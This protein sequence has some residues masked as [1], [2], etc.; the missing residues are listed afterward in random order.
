M[1]EPT[2][3][4]RQT[5][6]RDAILGAMRDSPGPLTVREIHERGAALVPGLGIATVYHTLK[7]LQEA[8]QI[9]TVVLPSGESRY[10]A[11][12]LGHHHH[13]HCRVCGWNPICGG[14]FLP[15]ARY[16]HREVPHDARRPRCP[17]APARTRV[18]PHGGEPRRAR[19]LPA[20]RTPPSSA[21]RPRRRAPSRGGRD[22]PRAVH[23]RW[24]PG[25]ARFPPSP[26]RGLRAR[27]G[28]A[29]GSYR[30]PGG[31]PPAPP[32]R[33]PLR[34]PWSAPPGLIRPAARPGRALLRIDYWQ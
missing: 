29:R 11:A 30:L 3:G 16:L 32:A 23:G 28:T 31:R 10:E 8:R 17:H 7:L 6:Q 1:S 33:R 22:E 14:S 27:G 24:C 12:E 21:W 19:R 20:R 13:F 25:R 18:R 15:S 34:R 4:Q 26:R 2:L 5:R 9:R